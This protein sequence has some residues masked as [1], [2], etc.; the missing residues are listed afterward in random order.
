MFTSKTAAL[1][2]LATITNKTGSYKIDG[3]TITYDTRASGDADSLQQIADDINNAAISGV[4]AAVVEDG[5]GFRLE[6]KTTNSSIAITDTNGL[7]ADLGINNR[8]VVERASN[9]ISDVL[10]G[11]TLTLFQAEPGT[12]VKLD[13]EED[14]SAVKAAI[15]QFV[16]DYNALRVFVN[17]Q[18]QVNAATGVKGED[19]GILFGDSAMNDVRDQLSN[20]VGLG[21]AGVSSAYT[22]LAQIGVTFVINSEQSDP[23]N[24]DTLQINSTKLDKELLSASADIRRLFAFD[25]TTSDPNVSLLSFTGNTSYTSGGYKLTVNGVDYSSTSAKV[26][27][28]LVALNTVLPVSGSGTFTINGRTI[29][30]NTATDT[31]T[32]LMTAINVETVNTGVTATVLNSGNLYTLNLKATS[33]QIVV[34]G[35]TGTLLASLNITAGADNITSANIDNLSLSVTV[36]GRT[37]TVTD[38]SGAEGLKLFY[39]S[40]GA[41]SNIQLDF[42][43]GIASKSFFSLDSLLNKSTGA[44]QSS[45]AGLEAQSLLSKDRIETMETRLEIQRDSLTSQFIAAELALAQMDS[46]LSTIRQAFE[47]LARDNS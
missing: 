38:K 27:G 28:D 46:L 16:A 11:V 34:S 44:I 45:I 47:L 14:L 20:D 29:S 15:E 4:S 6:I 25:F 22:V 5:T 36:S 33:K 13:V 31:L 17:A 3:T 8:L 40:T 10:G 1:E 35:D 18:N 42:T 37:I 12:T 2:T 43:Q 7:F 21:A 39:T 23:L 32:T 26:T 9:T 30:Y 24:F 41:T 19:S